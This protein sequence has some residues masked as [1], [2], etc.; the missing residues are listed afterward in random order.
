MK[1]KDLIDKL[2]QW[3]NRHLA[4]ARSLKDL[5]EGQIN[6]KPDAQTWSVL[7]C[8][9]HIN[10][11]GDFYLTE[12]E[13]QMIQADKAPEA[14]EFKPGWLGNYF[15]TSMLPKGKLNKV[16]T[17]KSMNPI[18]S[19]L[20]SKV[21][22][23]F[24]KQ[25]EKMIAL[26]DLAR[27]YNLTKVKTGITITNLIRLRLGDTLHFHMSH[28]ERHIQQIERILKQQEAQRVA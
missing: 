10:L 4:V 3:A 9:E 17:F 19:Q 7:E 15:A 25:T 18:H 5:P 11:Y 24:I 22:D 1:R 16:K 23:R 27:G 13:T 26:L 28:N 12:I 21:I 14:S 20:D 2:V 6:Y 8:L